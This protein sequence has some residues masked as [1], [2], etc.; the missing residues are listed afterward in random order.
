[1]P[2]TIIFVSPL[3]TGPAKHVCSLMRFSTS[4]PADSYAWRSIHTSPGRR[5]VPSFTTSIDARIGMPIASSVMPSDSI[6]ARWPSAVPPLCEPIAGNRNGRAPWSRS[7]SPAARVMV[8]DIGDSAAAGRDAD[9]ALRHVELQPIE[10]LAHGR[11]DIRDRIRNQFLAD[12]KEFHDS[13]NAVLNVEL[14]GSYRQIDNGV[15][16]A[17]QLDLESQALISGC[18]RPRCQMDAKILILRR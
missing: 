15:S 11:A 6:I 1:M 12:A 2:T 7:Q 8:G 13:S 14:K 18:M 9:V 4:T 10:L 16:T 5:T 3:C 17:L